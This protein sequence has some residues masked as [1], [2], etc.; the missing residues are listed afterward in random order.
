MEKPAQLTV[1]KGGLCAQGGTWVTILM[2]AMPF[3][4]GL[5]PMRGG[6]GPRRFQFLIPH[7][8]HPCMPTGAFRSLGG[9]SSLTRKLWS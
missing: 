3:G 5:I 7:H 6:T 2:A 8:P 4:L 9:V 1:D